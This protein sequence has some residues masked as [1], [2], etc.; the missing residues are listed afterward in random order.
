M[1]VRDVARSAVRSLDGWVFRPG[2]ATRL[3][4]VRI[5]LC[6]ILAARLA[7]PLY[8]QLAGQPRILYRPLSFMHLMPGMPSRGVTLAVEAAG[9]A[10]A[11]AGALGLVTRV[12]LPLALGSALLLDGMT[13]SL[14]KVV[15]N[16]VLLILAFVP[17]VFA[18]TADALRVRIRRPRG[19]HDPVVPGPS[20]RYGWPVRLSMILVAG[21]YFFTGFNKLVYSGPAW[22]L[23]DNL[24]WVLYAA[25]DGA[26][27]PIPAA[28]F[29]ARHAFLAHTVAAVTLVIEL[30]FPLVLWRPAAAWIFVPGAVLL[31]A[32]IGLTMHLDYSAWAATAVV[33]FTP[34]D[35]ALAAVRA[36][37]R[38]ARRPNAE[39][40]AALAG[41]AT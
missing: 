33:V 20:I 16:D 8:V 4:S 13:T 19:G 29:I 35:R 9:V 32:G 27:H 25:S 22:V 23:S 31:H 15:H 39:A 10:A 38:S 1:R 6:L 41:R 7:R 28:L 3:A 11:L 5:G 30:G 26:G 21:G 36:H 34:W 12:T 37:A 24:R 17:L 40:A 14:G 18:P 2:S